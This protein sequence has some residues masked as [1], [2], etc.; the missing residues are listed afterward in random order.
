MQNIVGL[1]RN[2]LDLSKLARSLMGTDQVNGLSLCSQ[3]AGLH[4]RPLYLTMLWGLI[5][6][7]ANILNRISARQISACL[8]TQGKCTTDFFSQYSIVS[9]VSGGKSLRR[10]GATTHGPQYDHQEPQLAVLGLN[11]MANTTI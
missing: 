6:N 10:C 3:Q 5:S 8:K 1:Y 11:I 9:L 2:S 7:L 4:L